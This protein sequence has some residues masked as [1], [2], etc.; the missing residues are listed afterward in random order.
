[1]TI[2]FSPQAKRALELMTDSSK[3]V[4]VTGKAGTGKSTLLEHFRM[5]TERKIVVLAP[6]GVAAINVRGETIHSFFKLKPGFELDEATNSR[7]T[8]K[9]QRMYSS[10]RTILIDEIS[11]VRADLLD[12][13]DVFLR[14]VRM[15]DRPFGGVQMIF[16]GD[17]YQLPPVI[18]SADKEKFFAEYE[19]PY[20]FDSKVCRGGYDLLAQP[21]EIECIELDKIYRQKD[22]KFIKLLNSVRSNS[23]TEKCLTK[24][25]SRVDPEFIPET[26]DGYIHLMTT[27]ADANRVNE[28]EL[29]KISKPELEFNAQISGKISKNLRPNEPKI[30]VKVG[31]QVMF[32][33]NDTK[34]RWVNGTLGVV[35]NI[36][37]RYNEETDQMET[38]LIVKIHDGELVEVG[39]HTWDISKYVFQ[40]GQFVR[41][42]IGSFSQMPIK[43]AWAITIHKSQGKTFEKAVIDLGWGSFAHGQTYVA[44]S[45]CTSLDGLVLRKELRLKDVITDKRVL[46]FSENKI[47]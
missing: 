28:R 16:F 38:I 15:D 34:R 41:E 13:I 30:S 31:A 45:R 47:N 17:L 5:F 1:M 4:F 2:K 18:T 33:N 32:I 7:I 29:A 27:N 11:M 40:E 42:E 35:R 37:D 43:L 3:N 19:S 23:L 10:L 46:D 25:N 26:E 24:L 22:Q 14:R 44:L 20:F 21:L 6:T 8:E 12:A 36:T 9:A 39:T